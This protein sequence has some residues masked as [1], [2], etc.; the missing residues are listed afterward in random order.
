MFFLVFYVACFIFICLSSLFV[1]PNV[2]Y[3]SGLHHPFSQALIYYAFFN[4]HSFDKI[5]FIIIFIMQFNFYYQ[6]NED[7]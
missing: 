4:L 1:L 5:V 6:Q 2:A 3:Y 7:L